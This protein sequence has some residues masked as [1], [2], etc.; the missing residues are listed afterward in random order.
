MIFPKNRIT[1][2]CVDVYK[3]NIEQEL[4]ITKN[5]WDIN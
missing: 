4:S 5:R 1:N 2:M 3:V